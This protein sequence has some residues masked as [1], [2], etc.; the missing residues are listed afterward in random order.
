[1][2]AVISTLTAQLAG[3]GVRLS[4]TERSAMQS[5]WVASP[6]HRTKRC[7][8]TCEASHHQKCHAI[9]SHQAVSAMVLTHRIDLTQ[10]LDLAVAVRVNVVSTRDT[11]A[12]NVLAKVVSHQMT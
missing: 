7:D 4:R 1:M 9:W 2:K 10:S 8:R 5:H 12:D 6:R 11:G 3:E